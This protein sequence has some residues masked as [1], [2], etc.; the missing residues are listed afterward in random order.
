MI[1]TASS[2]GAHL[3]KIFVND[4]ETDLVSAK[5]YFRRFDFSGDKPIRRAME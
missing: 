5:M 3:S 1:K 2:Q 4:M